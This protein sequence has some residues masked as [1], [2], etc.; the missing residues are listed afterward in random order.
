MAINST[1]GPFRIQLGMK[2]LL[3]CS[4]TVRTLFAPKTTGEQDLLFMVT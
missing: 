4:S 1:I 3:G 2:E